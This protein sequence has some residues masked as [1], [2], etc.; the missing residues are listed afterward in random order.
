MVMDIFVRTA[1]ALADPITYLWYSLIAV[2]PGIVAALLVIVIGYLVGFGV[3]WAVNKALHK[4]GV[5]KKFAK[6]KL[7]KSLG[8]KNLAEIIGAIVK[9]YIIFLFLVPAVELLNLGVFSNMLQ[10]FATWLPNLFVAMLIA[11]AGLIFADFIEDAITR[12]TLKGT[13]LL[14][15]VSRIAIIIFAA[16]IALRQIGIDVSLAENTVLIIV[17]AVALAFA[18]AVGMGFGYALKDE[19]RNIIKQIK[20]KL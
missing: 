13:Q 7:S 1:E 8:F 19:A 2:L 9:W 5:D 12:S 20:G 3:G 11:F 18:I 16:L 10:N 4:A 14:A 17:G 6:T 15:K